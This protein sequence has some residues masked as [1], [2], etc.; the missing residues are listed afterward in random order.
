MN[1][2]A[3]AGVGPKVVSVDGRDIDTP[4]YQPLS[5][6][7]RWVQ[8]MEVRA[9][10][11]RVLVAIQTMHD[12]G[13]CHRDLHRGNLVVDRHRP[14]IVDLEHVCEVD[15]AGPCYDLTGPC[16]EIPILADHAFRQDQVIGEYGVWWDAPQD[17]VFFSTIPLGRVFGPLAAYI[18]RSGS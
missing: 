4:L 12:L 17:P 8:Q 15:P 5:E 14:L 10:G 3:A 11:E 9:M 7:L 1:A 16:P 6:W 2:L 13:M 18:H